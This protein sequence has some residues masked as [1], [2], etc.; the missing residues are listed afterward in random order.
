MQ[1]Y[2]ESLHALAI[3]WETQAQLDCFGISKIWFN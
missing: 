1:E 2:M 3:A